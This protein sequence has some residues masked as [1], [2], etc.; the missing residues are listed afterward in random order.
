MLTVTDTVCNKSYE[1][2]EDDICVFD[3]I[4]KAPNVLWG[5]L[6]CS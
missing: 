4:S 1:A 2:F 3:K 5:N 6:G